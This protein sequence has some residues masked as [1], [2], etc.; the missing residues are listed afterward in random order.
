MKKFEELKEEILSKAQA[1]PSCEEGYDEGRESSNHKELLLVIK[2]HLPWLVQNKVV[3]AESLENDFGKEMLFDNDIYTS[4]EHSI[5]LKDV[6]SRD[7]ETLG[8]SQA[9]VETWDNSQATVKTCGNR[10]KIDHSL[11][12]GELCS[13]KDLSSK[14]IYV[15]KDKFNIVQI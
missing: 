10:S 1:V 11:G 2:K 12:D 4:G 5:V 8:N 15:K 6:Q 3:S 13:I 7:I 14:S 9:T